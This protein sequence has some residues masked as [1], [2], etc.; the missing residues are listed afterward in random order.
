VT[1]RW[2]FVEGPLLWLWDA[3]AIAI[4]L[5]LSFLMFLFIYWLLPNRHVE[6]RYTWPGALIAAVA[7]EAVKFGF[8]IYLA[9]FNDYEIYGSLAGAMVLLFWVFVSSNIM[10]FGAEVANEIPHVLH[11]EP[12]HG[13][14]EDEGDWRSSLWS[15]IRGLALAPGDMHP[16]HFHEHARHSAASGA[17]EPP[18]P[19]IEAPATSG[20]SRD[21]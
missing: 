2:S 7:F 1:E 18:V 10:L 20:S 9:N 11:E 8:T 12:R 15:F 14:E 4:P 13:F 21:G 6:L 17:L 16:D 19:P 3:G 5:L